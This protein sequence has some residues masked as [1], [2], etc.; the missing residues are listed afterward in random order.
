MLP[1]E[2]RSSEAE[3]WGTEVAGCWCRGDQGK[4]GSERRGGQGTEETAEIEG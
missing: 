3:S 4:G 1:T 2:T